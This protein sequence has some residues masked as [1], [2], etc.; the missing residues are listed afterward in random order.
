MTRYTYTS[1]KTIESGA[2]IQHS[3][4]YK[5]SQGNILTVEEASGEDFVPESNAVQ[6]L[7][8]DWGYDGPNDW[9][10]A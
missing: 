10:L 4:E 5:D 7:L 1:H 2:A 9:E 8:G 6:E 3:L